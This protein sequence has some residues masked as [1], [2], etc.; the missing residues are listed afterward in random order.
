M[1]HFDDLAVQAFG[2]IKQEQM[3]GVRAAAQCDHVTDLG[4]QGR[5]DKQ[6]GDRT[7]EEPLGTYLMMDVSA[8]DQRDQ[9]TGIDKDQ[10]PKPSASSSSTCSESFGSPSTRPNE[11]GRGREGASSD[12]AD[13]AAAA[14]SS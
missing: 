5:R 1:G 7:G 2:E 10:R 8:A 14:L 3:F 11:R 12:S 4:D 9:H 6:V 13:N